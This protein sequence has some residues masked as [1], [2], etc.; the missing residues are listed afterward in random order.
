MKKIPFDYFDDGR[1]VTIDYIPRLI[2]ADIDRILSSFGAVLLR[3]PKFSGKTTT[4]CYHAKSQIFL[5]KRSK[6]ALYDSYRVRPSMY[7]DGDKPRLIDEWQTYDFLWDLVK[8]AVD[9]AQ[10]PGQFILT[11][12]FS[13]KPGTTNHTGSMRIAR[14][15]MMTLS[16]YE[17]GLSTGG[18]SLLAM[19]NGAEI[20][21]ENHL[22]YE[23]ITHQMVTGG[24]PFAARGGLDGRELAKGVLD[25]IVET[26]MK[27]VTGRNFRPSLARAILRSL[28]RNI[29]TYASNKTIID[30]VKSIESISEP[31]FY[32]YYDGLLRLC[33]LYELES[34]SPSIRSKEAIRVSP[35]RQFGDV[36]IAAAALGI[37]E[38]DLNDDPR[39]RGFFFEN[40]VGHDLAVYAQALGATLGHYHDGRDLECDFTLHFPD[41]RYGLIEVKSS[42][43]QLADAFDVFQQFD[44]LIEK[45]SEKHPGSPMKPPSFKLVITGDSKFAYRLANGIYV[46]PVGALKP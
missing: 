1:K 9:Q 18:A 22:S 44:A 20:G 34:W 42:E 27:E 35:K 30:D 2:D 14:L 19:A 23:D 12:S 16:L 39:T 38:K 31:S 6:K 5:A 24:Y 28:A 11:G 4:A 41:G 7:L 32:E 15:N 26:D 17:M 3:G 46:A 21:G 25:S 8:E 36:S 37:G 43:N 33:V 40:F 13:P 45:Y 29:S 10:C